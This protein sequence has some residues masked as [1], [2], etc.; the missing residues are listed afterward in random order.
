MKRTNSKQASPN[1]NK[2]F[3]KK[4]I[5]KQ[6]THDKI[7]SNIKSISSKQGSPNKNN[8][9]SEKKTIR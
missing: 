5:K 1:K 6:N 9:L 8:K 3:Q 2:S 4:G 7:T